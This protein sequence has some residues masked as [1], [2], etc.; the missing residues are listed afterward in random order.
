[1]ALLTAAVFV[2][3]YATA[4]LGRAGLLSWLL[5]VDGD[6]RVAA[7]STPGALER[8]FRLCAAS[9]AGVLIA[10]LIAWQACSLLAPGSI[11]R[12]K[13]HGVSLLAASFALVLAHVVLPVPLI[14]HFSRPYEEY[15]KFDASY[16]VPS[17]V[18]EY[19]GLWALVVAICGAGA[20][21]VVPVFAVARYH[22]PA[23]HRAH[24]IVVPVLCFGSVL[25]ILQRLLDV[26]AII[27]LALTTVV[28]TPLLVVRRYHELAS[29]RPSRTA[30]AFLAL[31][32]LLLADW[33]CLWR[34]GLLAVWLSTLY[35]AAAGAGLTLRRFEERR[36]S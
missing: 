6:H 23:V 10:P 33:W 4:W 29:R 21:L 32:A 35:T 2:L 16:Y 17:P 25:L 24:A 18:D 26:R 14:A 7:A 34:T 11:A 12:A 13:R 22:P 15:A 19:L 36:K 3:G 9:L 8:A 27:L 28:L 30:K 31:L 20:A 1:L 5:H